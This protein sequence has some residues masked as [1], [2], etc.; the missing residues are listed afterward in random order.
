MYSELKMKDLKKFIV[1]EIK[2]AII[3]EKN[4][5]NRKKLDKALYES[6]NTA[7]KIKKKMNETNNKKQLAQLNKKYI[8]VENLTKIIENKI[9]ENNKWGN[10][11]EGEGVMMKAQ[12][13]SI[14]DNAKQ[15]YHMIDENDTFEDW[16]QYKVTIA[17]N[18]LKAASGYIKYFNTVNGDNK[19]IG[20]KNYDDDYEYEYDD[21]D[22]NEWDDVEEDELDYEYDD[23][24]DDDYDGFDF[25]EGEDLED[26]DE[27]E[28]DQ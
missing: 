17:E 13:R 14:M 5:I 23:D 12:L 19:M 4:R 7:S 15:L 16:L 25:N 24:D 2:N 10:T 18:Y 26:E 22:A 21:D 8:Q 6:V 20:S 9:K 11:V 28:K 3:E 1:S 27:E